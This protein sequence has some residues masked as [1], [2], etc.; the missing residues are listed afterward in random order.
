MHSLSADSYKLEIDTSAL[1]SVI[2]VSNSTFTDYN[3][4][5][6]LRTLN[7]TFLGNQPMVTYQGVWTDVQITIPKKTGVTDAS[8]YST[9]NATIFVALGEPVDAGLDG[10][11]GITIVPSKWDQISVIANIDDLPT[12]YVSYLFN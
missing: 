12:I 3:A 7:Y 5:T 4:E 1:F 8:N 11:L 2:F 10:T 9:V 6:D